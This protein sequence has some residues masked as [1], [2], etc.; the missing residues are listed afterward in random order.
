VSELIAQQKKAHT[1]GEEL[2]LP[3]SKK[4]VKIMFGDAAEEEFP[5]FPYQI[6]LLVAELTRCLVTLK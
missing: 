5:K 1:I 2:I 3:A 4:I 6:I